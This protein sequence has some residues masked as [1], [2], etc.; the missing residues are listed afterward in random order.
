RAEGGDGGGQLADRGQVEVDGGQA[1][2]TDDDEG[3]VVGGARGL[4]AD[5]RAHRLEDPADRVARLRGGDRPARDADGPARDGRG[6]EER[7]GI[8]QVGLHQ[9]V[10]RLDRAGRDAPRTRGGG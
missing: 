5:L 9:A 4:E 6:G 3:A 10:D 8:G 7:G 2:R 1:V